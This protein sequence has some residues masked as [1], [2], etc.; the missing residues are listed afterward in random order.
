MGMGSELR[1]DSNGVHLVSRNCVTPSFRRNR[2]LLIKE[3]GVGGEG[4]GSRSG[5]AKLTAM[6]VAF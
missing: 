4:Q 1:V 6:G 3:L 5:W 2:L